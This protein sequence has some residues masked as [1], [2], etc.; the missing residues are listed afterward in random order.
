ML[1]AVAWVL[2]VGTVLTLFLRPARPTAPATP[3]TLAPT[4][5]AA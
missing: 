4:T 5:T 2:Y 1:Q 3:T